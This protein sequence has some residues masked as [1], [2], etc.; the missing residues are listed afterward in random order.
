MSKKFL[1]IIICT[2]GLLAACGEKPK[3][4]VVIND[5]ME[6]YILDGEVVNRPLDASGNNTISAQKGSTFSLTNILSAMYGDNI[7]VSN[8]RCTKGTGEIN[9]DSI[10]VYSDI[11]LEFNL[12]VEG[13]TSAKKMN[14]V[15]E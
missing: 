7:E 5:N 9:G 14:V 11:V 12:A 3:E 4:P 6:S 13:N 8:I 15:I 10:T 2:A 1:G